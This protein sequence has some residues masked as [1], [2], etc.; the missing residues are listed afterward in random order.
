[1][2]HYQYISVHIVTAMKWAGVILLGISGAWGHG[3]S[4]AEVN[5]LR[6]FSRQHVLPQPLV[7]QV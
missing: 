5:E 3:R 2:A 7:G 6:M 4:L 1:M